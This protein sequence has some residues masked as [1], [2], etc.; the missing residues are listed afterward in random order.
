MKNI[1]NSSGFTLIELLVVIAIVSILAVGL[2]AVIN[3]A[4]QLAKTRDKV[5]ITAAKQ[6]SAAI[7]RYMVT[8]VGVPPINRNPCC[9]YSSSQPNFLQELIDSKELR[10][11]PKDPNGDVFYYYD[12][13]TGNSIG[14]IIVSTLEGIDPTTVAPEG[15]CR[16]FDQNWC[17]ST[18]PSKYYCV[19]NPY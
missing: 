1:N 7:Q 5:R 4:K 16:P 13:G 10:S 3:P 19:C 6:M 17:S 11:I 9:G 12:Y 2:I 15:S 8:S 18:I 14:T